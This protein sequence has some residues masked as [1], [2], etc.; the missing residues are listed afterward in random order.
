LAP[1]LDRVAPATLPVNGR[2]VTV[3]YSGPQPTVAV[4]VQDLFGTAV[5]PTVAGGKVPVVLQLLSPAGRPVQVTADLPGFWAGTWA[6]VRKEMAG[7]YPKHSWPADP[8][9]ASPPARR[10]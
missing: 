9:A 6:D 2:R 10:R 8:L 7:R 5:H 4:R 3:D 1:E